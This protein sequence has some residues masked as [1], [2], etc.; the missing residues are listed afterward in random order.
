MIN[1]YRLGRAALFAAAAFLGVG[2][3]QA[4]IMTATYTGV[5]AAD[6]SAPPGGGLVVCDERCS[7][8]FSGLFGL[9]GAALAG[10]AVSLSFT[11]DLDQAAQFF[12]GAGVSY[13]N[14]G[15]ANGGGPFGALAF[16][17]N[18][19][20]LSGTGSIAG[21]VNS[22][23]FG[24]FD[25]RDF[26]SDAL[27]LFGTTIYTWAEVAFASPAALPFSVAAPFS[28]DFQAGDT[29]DIARFR[30][31]FGDNP[32]TG[33]LVNIQPTRL[34]VTRYDTPVDPPPVDPPPVDPPPVDPPI[35][36]APEPA[37]WALMILGF[38]ACG[39][40][41]RRRRAEHA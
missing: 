30:I 38:A 25:R 9:S 23:A 35:S 31:Q 36:A 11:Y 40:A 37:A 32:L 14:G 24:L 1:S 2:P 7:R 15:S 10:R 5:V 28:Y 20:T 34:V 19:V 21:E 16:T 4:A 18:G 8:D 17:L 6:P 26:V 41:V 13:A 27:T 39:A 12:S 29:V 22:D 3:A 33:A